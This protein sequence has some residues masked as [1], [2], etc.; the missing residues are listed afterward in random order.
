MASSQ[1]REINLF[2]PLAALVLVLLTFGVVQCTSSCAEQ[3]SEQSDLTLFEGM[4]PARDEQTQDD[5]S[6]VESSWDDLLSQEEE[7]QEQKQEQGEEDTQSGD[8]QGDDE[9]DTG[10]W[11]VVTPEESVHDKLAAELHIAKVTD[12]EDREL[13]RECEGYY[14][15]NQLN[16]TEQADYR[17]YLRVARTHQPQEVAEGAYGR[18]DKVMDAFFAE[19]PEAF[20]AQQYSFPEIS[21]GGVSVTAVNF[22]WIC[23]EVKERQLQDKVNSYIKRSLKKLPSKA[24][25]YGKAKYL[26]EYLARNVSYDWDAYD[27]GD[28]V[29][30]V[31]DGY[32]A[33]SIAISNKAVCH[34]YASMYVLMLRELGIQAFLVG[35]MANGGSHTWCIVRLDGEYYYVDPTW[36]DPTNQETRKDVGIINYNYLCITTQKLE[37][38]HAPDMQFELP[39][40][41]AT[42]DNYFIRE[43]ADA[44]ETVPA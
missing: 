1:T 12:A 26:Y 27:R 38:D 22:V 17:A 36:A 25:D 14:A 6:D 32:D 20:N 44:P 39:R 4:P 30:R 24:D 7:K 34:G 29:K 18:S 11:P 15:Y 5:S 43:G 10:S 37:E 3:G 28:N 9:E 8:S 40:C 19:H 33:P 2:W 21:Q 31:G 16:A 35:G 13:A 42:A 41:T 23:D